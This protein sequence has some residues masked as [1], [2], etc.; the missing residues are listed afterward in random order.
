MKTSSLCQCGCGR[1]TNRGRKG[2][3]NRYVRGHNPTRRRPG[4]G[5]INQGHRYISVNGKRKAYARLVMENQLCRPLEAWEVVL[6]IDGDP[7][8]NE[9]DNLRVVTRREHLVLELR[10]MPVVWWTDAELR[11]AVAMRDGGFTIE[12]V[13]A[14]LGKSYFATRR[15]L[16]RMRQESVGDS[17]AIS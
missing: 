14:A 3:P 6:H 13:A 7:L 11:T 12:R 15:R 1:F 17:S 16:A 4:P 10:A 5:S 2:A 9:I 8:N